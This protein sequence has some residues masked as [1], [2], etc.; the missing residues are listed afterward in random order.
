MGPAEMEVGEAELS[1]SG[2]GVGL[3][4]GAEKRK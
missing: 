2:G 4:E 1:K 3:E